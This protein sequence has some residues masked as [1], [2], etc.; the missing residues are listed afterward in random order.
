[1]GAEKQ[2]DL[3]SWDDYA[4]EWIKAEFVKEV[5]A[6]IPCVDIKGIV[7]DGKNKLIA[8]IEY[9]NRTWS[10]DLNKTNQNFIRSKGIMPKDLIGRVFVCEKIKV[11]NPTTNSMQDSL[12]IT[13]IE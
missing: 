7:E 1:M 2:P 11:R 12:I 9:N 10:F 13:D 3:D 4:G 8:E 5:P 6:K